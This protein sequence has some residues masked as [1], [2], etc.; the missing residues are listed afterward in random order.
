MGNQVFFLLLLLTH[1][2]KIGQCLTY[3]IRNSGPGVM[4][5]ALWEAEA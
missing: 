5:Y 1:L 3:K 4:A 2:Y